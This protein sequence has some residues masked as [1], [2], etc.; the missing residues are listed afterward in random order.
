MASISPDKT[1][2]MIKTSVI[3]IGSVWRKSDNFA[4][5][6]YQS[7]PCYEEIN[8]YTRIIYGNHQ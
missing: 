6:F 7:H 1:R 4:A 8:H 5:V 2:I 3:W